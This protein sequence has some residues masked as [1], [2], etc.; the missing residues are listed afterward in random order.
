MENNSP[1]SVFACSVDPSDSLRVDR[2]FDGN[3]KTSVPDMEFCI[4]QGKTRQRYSVWL[5]LESVKDLHNQLTD[6]LHQHYE[7][8]GGL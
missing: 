8:P 5:D 7:G 4:S 6:A 1:S 3:D 2:F